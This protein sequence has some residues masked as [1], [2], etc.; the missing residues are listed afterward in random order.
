M[1][2]AAQ[3]LHKRLAQAGCGSRRA[4][5]EWI[6]AGRIT[7]NGQTA[8][9]GAAVAP[10]DVVCIDGKIVSWEQAAAPLP[11][12]LI[13]NKPSGEICSRADPEGRATV[14]DRLPRVAGRWV[15]VGRL[16]YTT[17][18]LLLFTNDGEL[19]H[20]LMHPSSGMEREYAVRV[21]GEVDE[22]MLRRLR[23]G[24]MLED[25]AAHFDAIID[26][27]GQGSNHWYHIVV[28]EGRNREVRRLWES[29]GVTVSRLMRVRYGPVSLPKGLLPGRYRE[30]T[31]GD[32][33]AL[34]TAAG[35][36]S[37]DTAPKA[38]PAS[39]STS[40]AAPRRA[41]APRKAFSPRRRFTAKRS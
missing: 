23:E 1:S 15:A 14:F 8:H 5:E 17:L 36:A 33:N 41:A 9:I 18:G 24:V 3:R 32:V 7:V 37:I 26:A 28:R 16:D 38:K 30:L 25:G 21:L 22:A 19:A 39:K 13:Y 6:R 40:K 29:Q 12:V 35:M 2:E 20:R 31:E 27:G 34:L 11:R 4:I 10:G